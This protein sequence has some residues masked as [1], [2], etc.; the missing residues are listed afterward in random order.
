MKLGDK[1]LIKNENKIVTYEIMIIG[2]ITK[3]PIY[4]FKECYKG[5]H[6]EE[7][8]FLQNQLLYRRPNI[9]EI[10]KKRRQS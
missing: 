4:Y 10:N 3:K 9:S 8:I 1:V 7:L 2:E 5:Y 6:P